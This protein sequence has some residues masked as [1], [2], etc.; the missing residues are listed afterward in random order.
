VNVPEGERPQSRSFGPPR[1][2]RSPFH[3]PVGGAGVDDK[4]S[5]LKQNLPAV[6]RFW[7]RTDK[8]FPVIREIT[9]GALLVLTVLGTLWGFTG[10]P[11]HNSPIVVVESGSMMHCEEP[12][13]FAQLGRDCTPTRWA[14][15]GTIDPGDLI[16]VKDV[17]RRSDVATQAGDGRRS[18]GEHGDVIIFHPDNQPGRTPVIHRALFWIEIHG[19]GTFSVPALGLDHVPRL[20]PSN[21]NHNTWD[22]TDRALAKLQAMCLCPGLDSDLRN[23]G[24]GPQH[25]G[26]ITRGDNNPGADQSSGIARLPVNPDWI[27]GKARGEIPW[28]GLV[29]LLFADMTSGTVNFRNAGGD[30]KV[31]LFITIG[32]L[33]GGP[34]AFEKVRSLLRERREEQ[35]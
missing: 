26:F 8:P 28:L 23:Q 17:D 13:G 7:T 3:R 9:V 21:T 31:M 18:Y 35:P 24:L 1:T 16:L 32:V 15:I 33:L 5:W 27:L 30:S 4:P 12:P 6:H 34:Y 20:T 14:R 29:K 11:L 19:D 25:S 22:D 2:R 10:Q